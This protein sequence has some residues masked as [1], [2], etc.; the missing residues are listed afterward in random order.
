MAK[1][2]FII[3]LLVSSQAYSQDTTGVGGSIPIS[4]T[5]DFSKNIH[6]SGVEMSGLNF[7]ALYFGM[8]FH[9]GPGYDGDGGLYYDLQLCYPISIFTIH[10]SFAGASLTTGQG[11]YSVIDNTYICGA[12]VTGELWDGF[13]FGVKWDSVKKFSLQLGW[14]N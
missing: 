2:L 1:Y 11:R 9:S 14:C 8:G 3:I 4:I 5:M 6:H 10:C 7:R 12:G 13:L